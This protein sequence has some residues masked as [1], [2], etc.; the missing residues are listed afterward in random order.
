[1]PFFHKIS[2]HTRT[3]SKKFPKNDI[4]TRVYTNILI[5]KMRIKIIS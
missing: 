3:T 1:M 5:I 4:R 2:S